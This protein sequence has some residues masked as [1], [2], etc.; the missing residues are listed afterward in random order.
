MTGE[1]SQFSSTI[2]ICRHYRIGY[3]KYK[4]S[5]KHIHPKENCD[6]IKCNNNACNKRHRKPCK[7]GE[8]CTRKESCAFLHEPK[9]KVQDNVTEDS[10]TKLKMESIIKLKDAKLEELSDKV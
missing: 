1:E 8:S 10:V 5:C 3:C 6:K 4:E 7:F 2:M 9:K